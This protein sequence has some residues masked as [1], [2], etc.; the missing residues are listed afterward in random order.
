VEDL[1]VVCCAHGFGIGVE[2]LGCAVLAGVWEAMVR[3][4]GQKF[5]ADAEKA[6]TSNQ[7]G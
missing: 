4:K 3:S 1:V 2:S 7:E 6:D 5:Q